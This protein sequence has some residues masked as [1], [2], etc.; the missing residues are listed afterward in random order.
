MAI[1]IYNT[2]TRKKEPFH[3]LEEGK[4]KMYV[5]GPTVYNYIHIG[6][7]RPAIVFDTVRRYFEYRGYDV[8]YV[9]NFTDVDDKLIKASNEMGEGVTEIANRFIK[10]YKEDVGALGVKEAVDHPRVTENMDEI[11]NF[12]RGLIDKGFAYEAEGDVY[13]RTRSFDQYGK[14]SHQSVDELQSGSRIEVGDKKED[15][16]DFTLW[17]GA[18]EGE[19]TWES[20]WGSG[21]PGWHIECSAMAKKYLGDTIDIH[22]GGQDLTFPHHEN[23]IAQSE[24]HNGESFARYW[25]HNGYINID[26]EKMSKSLGNFI[27]AHDLVK[28]HDPQVIRFFMLSVQYRHPINFSDELLK[29]A[30][31]SFDRIKNA[32]ENIQYRK[33]TTV[34][35][36]ENQDEWLDKI[37]DYKEQFIKEMD[38]DFNTANAISVLF[39]LTKTANLYLQED[40]T[41]EEVLSAF[42][43]LFEELTSV[44]GIELKVQDE[45][46]DEEIDALIEERKQARK[47]RDFERADQIR[48]ELKDRNIILEDTSQG[49]RWKRG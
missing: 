19:I 15:P 9:L 12:I 32:Y 6:N 38:D 46:L 44:L 34:S 33:T 25:M 7:A 4:V 18:K 17:K 21:R 42:E 29:G 30:K 48:D 22:A 8:H 24:A 16:L 1:N 39:D 43:K 3:P 47:N 45:L 31:S 23:E 28:K 13:F 35:L 40:Q 27:L 2:L 10:A 20:P 36:Q 37:S 5:C 49:T 41:H 11:I 26:N 14:L